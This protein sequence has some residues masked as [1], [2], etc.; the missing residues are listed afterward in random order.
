M[1]EWKVW[2]GK[3]VLLLAF[4]IGWLFGAVTQEQM[5]AVIAFVMAVDH[6]SDGTQRYLLRKELKKEAEEE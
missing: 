3:G 2:I 6:I 5:V 4:I 1:E